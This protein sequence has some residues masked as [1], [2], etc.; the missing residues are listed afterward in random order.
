MPSPTRRPGHPVRPQSSASTC[1]FSWRLLLAVTL[2]GALYGAVPTGSIYADAPT[3]PASVDAAELTIEYI[4]QKLE[5]RI[6]DVIDITAD[7]AF[8]QVSPRNGSRSEGELQLKALFPDLVR[9]AWTSPDFLSGLLW[10]LDVQ[11]DRF[12]QYQ[13]TTGEARHLPLSDVIADQTLIPITPEQ[14]FTLPSND[15]YALEIEQQPPSEADQPVA[16]V[17]AV[18]TL[19]GKTFRVWV[20]L[21]DWIVTRIE[22]LNASGRVELSAWVQ[23]IH[24][25]QGL[26]A[27]ELR[28]LPPGT[29]ERHMP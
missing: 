15:Q 24:I 13:P 19:S 9:A 16:I 2:V 7:I 25:N 28:G 22:S 23:E 6:Q 18:D 26:T 27:A 4:A 12:T 29:V 17:R 11:R 10:I 14:L 20:D 8:V 1:A 3:K 5:T 21:Q